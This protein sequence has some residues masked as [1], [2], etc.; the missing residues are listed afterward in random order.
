MYS[1]KVQKI[2]KRSNFFFENLWLDWKLNKMTLFLINFHNC[3]FFRM[4]IYRTGVELKKRQK[5]IISEMM[6]SRVKSAC[7]WLHST[8]ESI[9]LL[10]VSAK[11]KRKM[12]FLWQFLRTISPKAYR[13]FFFPLPSVWTLEKN[14]KGIISESVF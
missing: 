13:E 3:F 12:L 10:R 1:V 2:E 4:L 14:D 6:S 11:N 8:I 7:R 9:I 5:G